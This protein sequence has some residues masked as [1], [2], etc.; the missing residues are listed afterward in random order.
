MGK[1]AAFVPTELDV[2]S[3][4]AIRFLSVDA[5][6]QADS[7][8][9]GLPMGAAPMGYMLWTRY[10]THNPSNPHWFNRDRFILSAG[11]GSMLLYSLLYLTEYPLS[12][13]EIKHFRQWHSKTPGHPERDPDTGV[14]VT[15]GPLG[16]G[17]GNG[18]GEAMAEVHL[19]ARYNRPGHEVVN[20]YTYALV[21]DGDLME[22]VSSE[23]A[24][25]AGHFKLGKLIY[26][27]DNNH[28]TLSGATYLTFTEDVAARFDAY[29][30]HT[31]HV[32]DGNDLI[33]LNAALRNAQ[34][35]T[36]RPSLILVRT[37]IGYGSPH[38]HDTFE[39]HGSPLGEEE[40]RLTKL[41]L[42]WPVEPPFYVPDDVL[43]HFRTAVPQ[44]QQVEQ[45][46]QDTLTNYAKVYP[47][48]AAEEFRQHNADNLRTARDVD[49]GQAL[50]RQHIRKIVLH[51]TEV[52]DAVG[53]GDICVP[54][55]DFPHLFR[56]TVMEAD[57]THE[58]GNLLTGH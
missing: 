39:A 22:G 58:I 2:L 6:Q 45:A 49:A 14:A 8:H 51:A 11:H 32:E 27:Y 31:Q 54:G 28:I 47:E 3:I 23:A 9:P 41:N 40:V 24:S 37:H 36:E 38:K 17:F 10:L 25:L 1:Q 19:A 56:A 55:L 44:G 34:Q 13:D 4:N 12:I 50:D 21:S 48:L 20:H 46:W 30:W 43:A 7:G 5:V 35:E 29:G 52:I 26:L 18:V 53:I 42:G 16:Q 57:L 15:T 33:A